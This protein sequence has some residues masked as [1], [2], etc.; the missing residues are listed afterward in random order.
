MKIFKTK[1]NWLV[2]TVYNAGGK[3]HIIFVRKDKSGMLYFK[4]KNT[5][6][7]GI[8]SYNFN[9]DVGFDIREQFDKIL[10]Q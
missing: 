5:T 7:L 2:L 6:P 8:C 1:T 10:K 3:D 4:V 9:K